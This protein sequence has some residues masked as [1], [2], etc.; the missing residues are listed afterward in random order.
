MHKNNLTKMAKTKNWECSLSEWRVPSLFI[1]SVFL[2]LTFILTPNVQASGDNWEPVGDNQYLSD[3]SHGYPSI[4]FHPTTHDLYLAYV[5]EADTIRVMHYTGTAWEYVG[6][7]ITSGELDEAKIAFDPSTKELYLAYWDITLQKIVVQRYNGSSWV[8]VG[9]HG[10]TENDA[11]SLSFAFNPETGNPYIAY[12]DDGID[13]LVVKM[14]NGSSWENVGPFGLSGGDIDDTSLAFNP[15][16]NEPYVAFDDA[17]SGEKL[18]VIKY[19]GSSWADVGSSSVSSGVA[20]FIDLA[21][22]GETNLPYVIYTEAGSTLIVKK[23]DGSSWQNVGSPMGSDSSARHGQIAF[24]PSTNVPYISYSNDNS[25]NNIVVRKYSGSSWELVGASG[26]NSYEGYGYDFDFSPATNEP[27][28][29]FED[30]NSADPALNHLGIYKF[31]KAVSNRPT[32]NY[33]PKKSTKRNIVFTFRDL[34]ITTK[35][36]WVKVWL[37]GKKVTVKGAKR[38][39]DNL[40]VTLQVKYGKW[41]RGNYNLRMEYKKK[42]GN[43]THTDTWRSANALTIL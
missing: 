40:R 4:A 41:S 15:S 34:K 37:G 9:S 27:F 1:G 21:F 30:Y 6:S 3:T 26:F 38:S 11:R 7:A 10:V 24:C 17:G 22:N 14:Y 18:R 28:L 36:A 35:K 25:V 16:T 8:D 12:R 31:N 23:F 13:K 43:R 39:G 32:V 42:V 29:V 33:A 2:L 20:S 19:N 5:E